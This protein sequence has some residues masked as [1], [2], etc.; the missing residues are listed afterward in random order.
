[1]PEMRF[2]AAFFLFYEPHI[3]KLLHTTVTCTLV[4]FGND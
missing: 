2:D 1:M 3:S 4:E